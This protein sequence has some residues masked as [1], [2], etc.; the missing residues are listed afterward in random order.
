MKNGNSLLGDGVIVASVVNNGT[1]VTVMGTGSALQL[2]VSNGD[3]VS[4]GEL[5]FQQRQSRCAWKSKIG[6]RR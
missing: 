5:E 4:G 2:G 1:P 6:G 3:G